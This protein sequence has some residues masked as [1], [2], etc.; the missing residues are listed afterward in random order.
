MSNNYHQF[1]DTLAQVGHIET[2]EKML[3]INF[4]MSHDES[5]QVAQDWRDTYEH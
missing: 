1:L 4:G 5:I 3:R 2:E